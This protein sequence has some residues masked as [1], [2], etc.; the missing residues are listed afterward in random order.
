MKVIL[1][2]GMLSLTCSA[3]AIERKSADEIDINALTNQ[4]QAVGA[5]ANKIDLAWW[6]PVEFWEASLGQTEDMHEAQIAQMLGV[7]RNYDVL[8][9]IQADISPFGAFFPIFR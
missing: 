9:I 3:L 1:L 4:T 8:A 7:L 5:D 2:I 6:I